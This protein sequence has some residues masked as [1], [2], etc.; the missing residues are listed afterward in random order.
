MPI[1]L[2]F[3]LTAVGLFFLGRGGVKLPQLR[4]SPAVGDVEKPAEA[5][6]APADKKPGIL[7]R[8]WRVVS[9]LNLLGIMVFAAILFIF[10]LIPGEAFAYIGTIVMGILVAM[11]ILSIV[12]L[13]TGWGSKLLWIPL[14]VGFV[15]LAFNPPQTTAQRVTET[16]RT[17][18]SEG[19][20]GVAPDLVPDFIYTPPSQPLDPE[21]QIRVATLAN[22]AAEVAEAERLGVIA[23]QRQAEIEAQR[24]YD[25]SFVQAVTGPCIRVHAKETDCKTVKFAAF[26]QYDHYAPPGSCVMADGTGLEWIPLGNGWHRYRVT[27]PTVAQ[28]FTAEAA[29]CGS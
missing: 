23:A 13:V 21:E 10:M 9:S 1:E 14:L 25:E 12:M 7:S 20:Q 28:F 24:A 29:R 4:R 5:A 18:V 16:A 3:V 2:L 17:V 6:T 26:T 15:L 19:L 8:V 11:I 27:Q 22:Q